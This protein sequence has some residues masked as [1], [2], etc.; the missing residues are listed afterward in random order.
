MSETCVPRIH[1]NL[2][3]LVKFLCLIDR[4][5]GKGRVNKLHFLVSSCMQCGLIDRS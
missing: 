1:F 4:F 2:V 5:L 3:M